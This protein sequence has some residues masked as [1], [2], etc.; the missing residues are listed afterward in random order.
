MFF[1]NATF[2]KSVYKARSSMEYGLLAKQVDSPWY[3]WYG[4]RSG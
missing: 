3:G 2:A 4:R 1:N